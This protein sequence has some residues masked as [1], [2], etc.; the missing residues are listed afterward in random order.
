MTTWLDPED[1]DRLY[2]VIRMNSKGH[3]YQPTERLTMHITKAWALSTF[4]RALL[5]FVTAFVASI[6][7]PLSL[8]TLESAASAGI[9]AAISFLISAVASLKTGTASFVTGLERKSADRDAHIAA[10]ERE[11]GMNK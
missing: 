1:P 10:M 4:E 5:T 7:L 6:V 3:I 8:S 2:D 9:A 11:L